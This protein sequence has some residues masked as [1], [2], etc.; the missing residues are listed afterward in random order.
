MIFNLTPFSGDAAYLALVVRLFLG[1][2]LIIHGYAK[3]RSGWGQRGPFVQNTGIPPI[4]G[5]FAT[6]IEFFGGLLLVI[7]LIVPIAASFVAL[8]FASILSM[9]AS[10][11]KARFVSRDPNKPSYELE[12]FFLV[13]ALVLVVL[14]AGVFSL[15]SL[16]F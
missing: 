3:V 5:F 10:K 7:G 8:E 13:L 2:T 15:D 16:L 6:T 12:A 4:L 9:K 1:V 14:G 11:L